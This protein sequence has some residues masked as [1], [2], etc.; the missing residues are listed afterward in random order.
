MPPRAVVVKRPAGVKGEMMKAKTCQDKA[1]K[2][3]KVPILR[4][5]RDCAPSGW[6]HAYGVNYC[7]WARPK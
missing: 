5:S 7:H 2:K 6:I 3:Y 4:V 1:C